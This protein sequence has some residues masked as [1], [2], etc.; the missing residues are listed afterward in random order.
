MTKEAM[1]K[2]E[3]RGG[4]NKKQ[5]TLKSLTIFVFLPLI[6]LFGRESM[7][8]TFRGAETKGLKVEKKRERR[9]G[10]KRKIPARSD[11]DVDM[12]IMISLK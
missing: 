3:T 9:R 4:G 5:H 11:G 6:L 7:C 8:R 12:H 10:T 1:K 2:E